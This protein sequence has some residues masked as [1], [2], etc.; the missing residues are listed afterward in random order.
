MIQ[1]QPAPTPSIMF[2]NHGPSTSSNKA[3][4]AVFLT[5]QAR[6]QFHYTSPGWTPGIR[7]HRSKLHTFNTRAAAYGH[8]SDKNLHP[9]PLKTKN[10]KQA[11]RAQTT[12]FMLVH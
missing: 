7:R 10:W 9:T 8:H 11:P 2:S 6:L 5:A 4:K 12:I 3:K 1:Q